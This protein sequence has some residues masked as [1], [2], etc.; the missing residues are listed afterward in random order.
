MRGGWIQV[1]G[2]QGREATAGR[3]NHV[4]KKTRV[5]R[6]GEMGPV[7][8]KQKHSRELART[9]IRECARI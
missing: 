4:C 8:G 2:E 5:R 6:P 1:L 7:G 3:I 9:E